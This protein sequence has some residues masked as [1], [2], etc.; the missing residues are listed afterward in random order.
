MKWFTWI[1]VGASLVV[2]I[3]LAAGYRN[4][5]ERIAVLET[6]MESAQE[7]CEKKSPP[8]AEV[9]FPGTLGACM[10]ELAHVRMKPAAAAAA[11]P[12]CPVPEGGVEGETV[13]AEGTG[14]A[15]GKALTEKSA[16]ETE[17]EKAGA[18][19][20]PSMFR[21]KLSLDDAKFDSLVQLVCAF[22]ALRQAILDDLEDGSRSADQA[23]A[24]L[25]SMRKQLADDTEALLGTE[26]YAQFRAVGGIGALGG[27]VGCSR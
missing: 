12:P 5:Q 26:R 16:P 15:K 9:E 8:A 17:D 25:A 10:K 11:C 1:S 4:G 19:P 21:S 14:A 18:G 7:R 6:T 24:E 23:W 2:I 22:E 20:I 13:P 27:S 3:L